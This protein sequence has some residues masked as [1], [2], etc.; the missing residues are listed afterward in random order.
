MRAMLA[1]PVLCVIAAD[2]FDRVVNYLLVCKKALVLF[3][4]QASYHPFLCLHIA[5]E[6][7]LANEAH[8]IKK[9][10]FFCIDLN[11]GITPKFFD[12]YFLDLKFRFK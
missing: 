6:I 2:S 12:D 8:K 7:T 3:L 4:N 11:Y 5:A 10:F 9:K 1:I